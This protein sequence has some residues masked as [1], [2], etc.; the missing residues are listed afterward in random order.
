MGGRNR[1]DFIVGI[2]DLVLCGGRK[3]LVSGVWIE[4]YSVFVSGIEI[5]FVVEWGSTLI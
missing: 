5:D 4:I 3:R 2:G 1:L